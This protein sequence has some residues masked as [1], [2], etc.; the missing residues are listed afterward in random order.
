VLS[1]AFF[2]FL[3]FQMKKKSIQI[4]DILKVRNG[5]ETFLPIFRTK[6]NET[7]AL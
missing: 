5:K 6:T 1:P 3:P 7:F 4:V 2:A